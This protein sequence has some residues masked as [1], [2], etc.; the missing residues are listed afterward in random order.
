MRKPETAD[1]V[2]FNMNMIPKRKRPSE[3]GTGVT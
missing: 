2:N 1:H 3:G